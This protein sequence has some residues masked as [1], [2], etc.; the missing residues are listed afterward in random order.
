MYVALEKRKRKKNR[1]RTEKSVFLD[2]L[3]LN[4]LSQLVSQLILVEGGFPVG[5]VTL[6][7]ESIDAAFHATAKILISGLQGINEKFPLKSL[8]HD[9]PLRLRILGFYAVGCGAAI[10]SG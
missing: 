7:Q 8:W 5:I 3:L 6:G 10:I 2:H 9:I 4:V 1:V